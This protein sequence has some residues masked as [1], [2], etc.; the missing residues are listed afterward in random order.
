MARKNA[1][2][3][4]HRRRHLLFVY[5]LHRYFCKSFD[6]A[7]RAVFGTLRNGGGICFR[8]DFKYRTRY[9]CMGLFHFEMESARTGFAFVQ[10]ALVFSM[11]TGALSVQN[12]KAPYFR[13]VATEE[14]ALPKNF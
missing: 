9:G 3:N 2:V 10:C 11:Y 14:A 6:L 5:V 12:S 1:L 7:A 13:C 4:G 8:D